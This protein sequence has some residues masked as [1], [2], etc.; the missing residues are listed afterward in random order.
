MSYRFFTPGNKKSHQVVCLI[1][2]HLS[3]CLMVLCSHSEPTHVGVDVDGFQQA[4]HS[5]IGI[6]LKKNNNKQVIELR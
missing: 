1:L 3:D 5:F 2:E 6:D 4:G